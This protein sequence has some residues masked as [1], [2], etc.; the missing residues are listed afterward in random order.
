[1]LRE[2]DRYVASEGTT[3]AR[4]PEGLRDVIGRRLS[5][6]GDKT[7]QVLS[8]A[9]VMGREFRLDVL[10]SVSG[11]PEA[12]VE[13]AVKEAEERAV[14]EQRSSVGVLAF[15]FTHAFFRQTLYE[16]IFASQRLRLH[17]QVARGL[18]TVYARRLEE[19]AVS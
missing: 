15:R 8:V 10:Q 4:I 13:A 5:H 1:M 18:E 2:G 14:L 7:N 12:E 16:E 19:H 9:A 11:L 6:F 17:Q 3:D